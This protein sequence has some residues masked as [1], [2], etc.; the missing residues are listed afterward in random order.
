MKKP[1]QLNQLLYFVMLG[2]IAFGVVA[3]Q[4]DEDDEP[5][6]SAARDMA[7]TLAFY[8]DAF[9]LVDRVG[10]SEPGLRN[11]YGLPECAAVSIDTLALPFT[12]TIDFGESNCVSDAGIARRGKIHVT[13]SGPYQNEGTTITSTLENYFVMDHQLEG[14]RVVTN[15][16]NNSAGNLHYSVVES[17]VTLTHPNGNWTSTWQSTRN[18]EWVAGAS[19]WWNPFDDVYEITGSGSGV[20]RNGI[21]YTINII[22]ALEVKIVCPWVTAGTLELVPEGATAMYL[23]YGD[24][25]CNNNA[26]VTYNGIDYNI[27]LN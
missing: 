9:S 5:D 26:V 2:F 6:F 3:C 27:T 1:P 16:G 20:S 4:K 17:G 21:P 18:R 13:I 25:S 24:G 10:K 7:M 19:T 12:V 14:T 11:N 8:E 22:N 23:D 15:L